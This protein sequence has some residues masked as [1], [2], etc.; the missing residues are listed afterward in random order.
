MLNTLASD[1]RFAGRMLRKSPVFTIVAVVVVSLGTGAVTTIYSA[2]NAML[3]RPLPGTAQPERLVEIERTLRDG[4][5]SLSHS[6]EEWTGL[7]ERARSFDDIAAWGKATFALA[8]G[9]EGIAV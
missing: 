8:S 2:M 3:F 6:H 5:G 4:S 9:G 1:L 7:R